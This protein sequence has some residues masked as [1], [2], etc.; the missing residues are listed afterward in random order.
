MYDTQQ[1]NMA[2]FEG[3]NLEGGLHKVNSTKHDWSDLIG[4]YRTI[5]SPSKKRAIPNS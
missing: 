1:L 5:Q 3:T 4:N 2:N